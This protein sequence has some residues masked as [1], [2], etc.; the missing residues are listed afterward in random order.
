MKQYLYEILYLLGEFRKKLPLLFIY[1]IAVSLLD[2]IGVGLIYPFLSIAMDPSFSEQG[3]IKKI[4]DFMGIS[5]NRNELLIYFGIAMVFIFLFKSLVGVWLNWKI[6]SFGQKQQVRLRSILMKHYQNMYY[7]DYIDRNSSDF[8]YSVQ[9]LAVQYSS[10]V[11]TN[12]LKFFSEV[13]VIAA[14]LI[15]LVY[16]SGPILI[17]VVMFFIGIIYIYDKLLGKRNQQYGKNANIAAVKV[18]QGVSEGMLGLKE[19]RLLNKENY[20]YDMVKNNSI[21]YAENNLKQSI[22]STSPRY[23]I[24]FITIALFVFFIVGPL[25]M[26]I[27]ISKVIPFLGVLGLAAMRLMP[28]MNIITG[29]LTKLRY[30]KDAV[31]RLYKEIVNINSNNIEELKE[32]NSKT[33]ESF[34]SLKLENTSYKYSKNLNFILN[35][36]SFTINKGETIGFMGE[37]GSGKTT[38]IDIIIGLL[39]PTDGKLYYNNKIVE[40]FS[41]VWYKQI[42][43]LPQNTFLLDDTVKNNITLEESCLDENKLENVLKNSKLKELVNSLPNGVDTNIGERGMQLSGGQRQRIVLARALY[44]DREILVMDE[45]TSALDNETEKEIINEIDSLKGKKTILIIAHRLSTLQ[46]CDKIFKLSNGKLE[47]GT[48]DSMLKNGE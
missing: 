32:N 47:V 31:N 12:I 8:I 27:D 37:S 36:I 42:A 45:A 11:I 7:R 38:L 16:S 6:L 23:L 34:Y 43:Y 30:T 21:V 1:F 20:F 10:G 14:L 48:P 25:T 22:I 2:L 35:N 46:N 39:V 5:L 26:G 44:H 15:F 29:N 24:E 18:G 9:T 41:K 28:S 13:I 40:D 4:I 17:Y 33:R 3:F 19:I